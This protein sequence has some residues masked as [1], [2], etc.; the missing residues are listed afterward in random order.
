MQSFIGSS[1]LVCDDWTEDRVGRHDCQLSL[2][3]NLSAKKEEGYTY[4]QPCEVATRFRE[5]LKGNGTMER[6]NR[7]IDGVKVLDKIIRWYNEKRLHGAPGFLRPVDYYRG[8]P[9]EVC[10][11]RRQ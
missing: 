3:H 10:A 2:D 8:D 9:E 4:L 1:P 5:F 7:T 11:I 6:A